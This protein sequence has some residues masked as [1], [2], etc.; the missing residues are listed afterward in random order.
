MSYPTPQM[1]ET[2]YSNAVYPNTA[3]HELQHQDAG[4]ITSA[5]PQYGSQTDHLNEKAQHT[6]NPQSQSPGIPQNPNQTPNIPQQSYQQAQSS[7]PNVYQN[8]VPLGALQQGP[9]PVDCPMCGVRELT[10]TEFVSGGT[11][12]GVA[13][14]LCLCF[15]LGC[16]PYLATWFKDVEHKCG[17]CGTLLAVWKRSGRTEVVARR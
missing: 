15:C 3:P 6:P 8:A 7:K 1:T 9:A 12:H 4:P 5:P 16:I 11:T 10:R 13:A 17:H 2:T 14:L